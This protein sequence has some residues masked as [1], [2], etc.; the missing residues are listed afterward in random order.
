MMFKKFAVAF[1][2]NR[3]NIRQK[4][5]V[6]GGTVAAIVV[7]GVVLYRINE[8]LKDTNSELEGYEETLEL[9][10]VTAE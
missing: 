5:V 10:E 2:E 6:V 8:E 3:D 4:L 7:A 1:R 9:Y